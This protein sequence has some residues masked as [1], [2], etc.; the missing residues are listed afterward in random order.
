MS[1]ES[2]L[3]VSSVPGFQ[4]FDQLLAHMFSC[5]LKCLCRGLQVSYPGVSAPSDP[6]HWNVFREWCGYII[7]KQ[8]VTEQPGLSA[9]VGV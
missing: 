8:K 2:E 9:L 6:E 7:E 5:D 3:L 4:I 1:L